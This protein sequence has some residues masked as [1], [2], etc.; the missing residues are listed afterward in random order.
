MKSV[1]I[2]VS[3]GE[4]LVES[5]LTTVEVQTLIESTGRRAVLKGIGGS[6]QGKTLTRK[7][8]V[9][10]VVYCIYRVS[11]WGGVIMDLSVK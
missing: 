5:A 7:Y 4:V 8:A 1:T 2:D 6:E 10:S 9:N 3:K 11:K